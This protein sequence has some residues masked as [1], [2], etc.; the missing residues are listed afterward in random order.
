MQRNTGAVHFAI[1]PNG[2]MIYVPGGGRGLVRN[3]LGRQG[4]ALEPYGPTGPC[5]AGRGCRPTAGA[6]RCR[7]SARAPGHLGRTCGLA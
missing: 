3:L 2:T 1:A 7:S 5:I 4:G 6:L